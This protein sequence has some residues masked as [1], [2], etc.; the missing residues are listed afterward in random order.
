MLT[1]PSSIVCTGSRPLSLADFDS[2]KMS[3]SRFLTFSV[4]GWSAGSTC[5]AAATNLAFLFGLHY[6][7][8]IQSFSSL[9]Q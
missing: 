9:V 5:H 6:R 8:E 4:L 2:R 3:Q 7:T 1:G